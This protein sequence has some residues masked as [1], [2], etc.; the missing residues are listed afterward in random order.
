MK[1]FE[2]FLKDNKLFV[3]LCILALTLIA[4]AVTAPFLAPNDPFKTNMANSL[5]ESGGRFPLGTDNLGRCIF[6]RL[7]YG[8]QNSL[9]MTFSLVVSVFIVGTAVGTAA[10]YFGGLA[11]NI[12]MRF[13]DV[14]LAFPGIIFAIAIAGVLGPSSINTVIALIAVNWVKY[15][16][17][18][19]SLVMAVKEKEYVKLAKM[20]GAREYQLILK[21]VAPNII[22]SL[23]VM[24]TMDIGTMMLEISSLSFLGLGPQPPTPEWGY[25]LSEGR[26]YMQTSP[27]LMIYPGIAIFITVMIFNLLGDSMRDI[28]DPKK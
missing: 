5:R 28:L 8:G 7:L 6:S 11:D 4:A 19:R 26:N 9:K 24:A 16:R 13:S 21:Y 20:G 10:G 14:F 2:T 22:P 25:M 18:S 12:I 27:E 1:R 17:V 23:V 15:A 3:F